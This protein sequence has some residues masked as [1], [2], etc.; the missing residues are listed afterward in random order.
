MVICKMLATSYDHISSI[1]N[2]NN[3]AMTFNKRSKLTKNIF[4]CFSY[5]IS[6]FLDLY[7]LVPTISFFIK[8][9]PFRAI[10]IVVLK[11]KFMNYK[12]M[13]Q[14]SLFDVSN[15]VVLGD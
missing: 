7:L 10:N 6:H 11:E 4:L 8:V 3:C 2:N 1:I 5:T 12:V 15:I 13:E 9:S 14:K